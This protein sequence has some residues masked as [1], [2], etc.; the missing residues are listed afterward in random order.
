[1]KQKKK[2]PSPKLPSAKARGRFAA[3]PRRIV[4]DSKRIAPEEIS[5]VDVRTKTYINGLRVVSERVEGASSLC[6]GLWVRA[7]SRHE[8]IRQHG[9]AHFIEHVVFKGTAGRTMREIMRS[10]E[11][12]GGYL[13][14][15]TTKEHTCFY[16]WTRTLHLD[17]S[18]SVLFDLAL[19]P[20][21]SAED[22]EREKS[23]IIEEI[24]GIEDEPDEMVFDLF[25]EEIFGRHALA[26]PIIG[27]PESIQR[28][29]RQTLSAF[30]RKHYRSRDIV[31]V[32]SGSHE[33][34]ALF[35]AID[36]AIKH[37]PKHVSRR[38]LEPYRFPRRPQ[39]ELHVPRASGQQAH[40]I[41]GRRAP[42]VRSE[43]HLA[44]SALITLLGVGM[45]SRLN[46][47]LREE[48]G[49][50]Y[51]SVA[52]YSPFEDAGAVGL[53]IA[54]A[55][56]NRERSLREMR[57][58]LRGLTTRPVSNAELDRAKEQMIGSVVLPMESIS[59]RMMRAA[60]N[61]LYFGEYYSVEH[62][63]QKISN[64]PL[65]KVRDEVTR[66]FTD[67]D[68]YTLVSV[69]PEKEEEQEEEKE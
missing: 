24:N 67:E 10:I 23:V 36:R 9:I 3:R 57:R 54:T 56:E 44:I 40:L 1:M 66:L 47:R 25:E 64:L 55:I 20:K 5:R 35:A 38:L 11:A 59:N 41:L 46:L 26:H 60:Q 16:T 14:A 15:F 49:L 33:H 69:V 48:L 61:E 31:I 2:H 53:Y 34:D 6:V 65:E 12:R 13:N 42:G 4:A 17:E 50:A 43:R 68:R 21:F 18:V 32:A 37:A 8:S 29:N 19:R 51:D 62:D 58:I 28:M 45:S 30:H 7:G 63:I 22:I 39:S 27:T 52:F